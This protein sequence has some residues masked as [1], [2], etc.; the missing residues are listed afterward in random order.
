MYMYP[1]HAVRPALQC[2]SNALEFNF[3]KALD[4]AADAQGG[5]TVGRYTM[6]RKQLRR[7]QVHP[8]HSA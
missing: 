6:A 5:M 2:R 1:L 8:V 4:E 3:N 7:A